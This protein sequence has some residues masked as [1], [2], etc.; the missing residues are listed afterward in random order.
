MSVII[1][2]QTKDILSGLTK[3]VAAVGGL[4]ML[5]GMLVIVVSVSSG[6]FLG[7]PIL[8]DSEAAELLV[9]AG[10]FSFLPYSHL[11][12]GNIIIDFF[13]K[14]LPKTVQD[15]L[16]VV[17]HFAFA[18]VAGFIC[19]RLMVGGLSSYNNNSQTMFLQLPEWP[20]YLVG[21]V[22]GILWVIAILFTACEHFLR[23]RGVVAE[24]EHHVDFG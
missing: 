18:T 6:L 22:A 5:A 9:G 12:G 19:W 2:N 7:S 1:Y 4:F 3:A 17:T 15:I 24:V 8:G 10:I 20:V 14:T 23:M 21:S 13:A 16:D 11:Q